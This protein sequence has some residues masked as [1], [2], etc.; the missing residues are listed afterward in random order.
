M[1]ELHIKKKEP[2]APVSLR[3]PPETLRRVMLLAK[4]ADATLAQT[5]EA[6]VVLYMEQRR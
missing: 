2:K 3:L 4:K 5:L 6:I 1:P